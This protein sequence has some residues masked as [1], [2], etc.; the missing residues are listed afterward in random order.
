MRRKCPVD[1]QL[2]SSD[3]ISRSR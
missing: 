1:Q 3:L 2:R